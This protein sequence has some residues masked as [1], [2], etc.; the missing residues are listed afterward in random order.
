LRMTSLT[1]A[2]RPPQPLSPRMGQT[3]GRQQ[4]RPLRWLSGPRAT[5]AP[6]ARRRP[7]T[8]QPWWPPLGTP[9]APNQLQ[10]PPRARL[11]RRTVRRP[12]PVSSF[13]PPVHRH[14]HRQSLLHIVRLRRAARSL[15]QPIR[16][17]RLAD[18]ERC[19]RAARSIAPARPECTGGKL[20]ND[21]TA[22]PTVSKRQHRRE[23]L[24]L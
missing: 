18:V 16:R 5:D 6:A 15:Q 10:R 9:S 7:P 21:L 2:V 19:G 17:P 14:R 3:Q 20:G 24:A 13:F 23:K 12:P 8:R 1:S 4:K 11:K 22:S